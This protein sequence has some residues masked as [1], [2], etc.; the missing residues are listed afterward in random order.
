MKYVV[1]KDFKT[2]NRRFKA[3]DEICDEDIDSRLTAEQWRE[4]GFIRLKDEPKPAYAPV[5]NR[6][7]PAK[8]GDE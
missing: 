3:G 8:P 1:A 4:R 2:T 7:E 5:R 6:V